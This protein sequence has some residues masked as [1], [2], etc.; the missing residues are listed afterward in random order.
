M[1]EIPDSVTI[2]LSRLIQPTKFL[3]ITIRDE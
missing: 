3:K 1:G 2:Q